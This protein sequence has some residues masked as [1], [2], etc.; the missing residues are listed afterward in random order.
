MAAYV[1]GRYRGRSKKRVKADWGPVDKLLRPQI[2]SGKKITW[3][4]SDFDDVELTRPDVSPK[5]YNL[6]KAFDWR[7]LPSELLKQP[8]WFLHDARILSA[9]EKFLSD[10][11]D[12]GDESQGRTLTLKESL[13]RR[14]AN[15]Q[16]KASKNRAQGN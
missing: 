4:S 16:L 15:N 1:N 12:K 5:L 9:R 13:E 6:C 10:K 8:D 2:K 14:R 3:A 11:D 7:F